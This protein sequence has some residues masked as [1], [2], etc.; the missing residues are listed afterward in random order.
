[1]EFVPVDETIIEPLD[2]PNS[3]PTNEPG[4]EELIA[5]PEMEWS[6]EL[7]MF[8]PRPVRPAGKPAAK[9]GDIS[10]AGTVIKGAAEK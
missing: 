2:D 5:E 10:K 4:D 7:S 3:E 9:A 1:M 8:I 6:D